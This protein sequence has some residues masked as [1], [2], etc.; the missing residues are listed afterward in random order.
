MKKFKIT[1]NVGEF[2][3]PDNA[4]DEEYDELKAVAL[5][6]LADKGIDKT[7]IKVEL[8]DA[9][10]EIKEKSMIGSGQSMVIGLTFGIVKRLN[11]LKIKFKG[12]RKM[13]NCVRRFTKKTA[14]EFL[15]SNGF[16]VT[17]PMLPSCR[18]AAV[19]RHPKLFNNEQFFITWSGFDFW[20]PFESFKFTVMEDL[21]P[22][23]YDSICAWL[24]AES[25][26]YFLKKTDDLSAIHDR[27]LERL[28]TIQH[29]LA[30]RTVDDI[31][32]ALD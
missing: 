19:I 31:L 11:N 17:T 27:I 16:E 10:D 18:V 6:G 25:S 1:Y 5:L 26:A 23:P 14:V 24:M 21:W 32:S 8:V 15:K 30:E 20:H 2:T 28:K 22:L 13:F 3:V 9:P 12:Y 4:T 7:K 29:I